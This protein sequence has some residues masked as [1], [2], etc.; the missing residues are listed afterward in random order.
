MMK[1]E[2]KNLKEREDKLREKLLQAGESPENAEDII[3]KTR[4]KYAEEILMRQYADFPRPL[5][6]TTQLNKDVWADGVIDDKEMDSLVQNQSK[7]QF[8]YLLMRDLMNHLATQG[9]LAQHG[10]LYEVRD[11]YTR[12]RRALK[13]NSTS[14][15]R[16]KYAKKSKANIGLDGY[17]VS[18]RRKDKSIM[19]RLTAPEIA[20]VQG[21]I[22]GM[23][24]EPQKQDERRN[25]NFQERPFEHTR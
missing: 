11:R 13:I 1:D 5:V 3:A 17:Q 9:E 24:N 7:L 8:N 21:M 14:I 16:A 10:K 25:N 23:E 2:S 22:K 20:L 15:N 19:L 12:L 6:Q 4:E 18:P